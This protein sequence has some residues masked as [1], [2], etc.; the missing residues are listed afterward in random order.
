MAST[1][2][3]IA[4]IK[5]QFP[6]DKKSVSTRRMKNLWKNAFSLYGK[7]AS[8]LK[9]LKISE[10]IKKTGVQWQKYTSSLKIDFPQVSVLYIRFYY[11][12]A[13]LLL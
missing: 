3:K 11:T 12:E 13:R 6:P 8:T 10:N 7:V 5:R 1:S 9:N 2:R 4:L